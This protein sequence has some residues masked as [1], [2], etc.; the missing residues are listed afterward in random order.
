MNLNRNETV[1][2]IYTLIVCNHEQ[3]FC[4]DCEECEI[5]SKDASMDLSGTQ[6]T[7][8]GGN[9]GGTLSGVGPSVNCE[10]GTSVLSTDIIMLGSNQSAHSNPLQTRSNGGEKGGSHELFVLENT[11]AKIVKRSKRRE[12]SVDEDTSASAERLKAKKNLDDPGTSKSKS[13]LS[14]SD[15]KIVNNIASLGV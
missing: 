15:S 9:N 2:N 13:F 1:H 8:A 14:F 11:T 12:G 3:F 7:K 6:I 10:H 5:P 4:A